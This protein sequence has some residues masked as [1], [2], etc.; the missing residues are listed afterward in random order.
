MGLYFD[1]YVVKILVKQKINAK[2][3]M[4]SPQYCDSTLQGLLA[5]LSL[6]YFVCGV[7]YSIGHLSWGQGGLSDR[8]LASCV[9]R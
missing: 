7:Q 8:V 9:A 6:C 5:Y 3:T 2:Y 4:K 1:Q